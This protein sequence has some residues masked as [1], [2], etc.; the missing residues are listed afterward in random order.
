[1]SL[2]RLYPFFLT[3]WFMSSCAVFPGWLNT[4]LS[5]GPL[6]TGPEST[7]TGIFVSVSNGDDTNPGTNFRKPV[8]T[9]QMGLSNAFTYGKSNIYCE[10]GDYKDGN[11][12]IIINSPDMSCIYL[13][14]LTNYLF[15]GGWNTAFTEKAGRTVLDKEFRIHHGLSILACSNIVVDGFDLINSVSTNYFL[16]KNGGGIYSEY[17]SDLIFSNMTISNNTALYGSGIFISNGTSNFISALITHNYAEQSGG[18]VYLKGDWCL[19]SGQVISN[20]CNYNGGGIYMAGYLCYSDADVTYNK[21]WQSNGGGYYVA[22]GSISHKITGNI[23]YNLSPYGSGAGLFIDGNNI[24]LYNSVINHNL[25]GSSSLHYTALGGGA[26]INADNVII[27]NCSFTDNGTTNYS[28]NGLPYGGA[29]YINDSASLKI[30][31]NRFS[32]NYSYNSYLYQTNSIIHLHNNGN[33][34]NLVLAYNRIAGNTVSPDPCAILESGVDVIGHSITSNTFIT[35]HLYYLYRD[36]TVD[37][38]ATTN[39]WIDINNTGNN[40]A[41]IA[42]GNS[43]E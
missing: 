13:A 25:S 7:L 31:D 8:K 29:L 35:N 43:V 6:I 5:G 27:T 33:I 3:I 40:D 9:I 41:A 32:D 36:A 24:T 20:S 19:I 42:T 38:A 14:F 21:S 12:L 1:M 34:T 15:S 30:I 37:V 39:N 10:A 28:A 2:Y 18:G 22:D 16:G 4:A 11:G 26:Y 23:Q 17:S